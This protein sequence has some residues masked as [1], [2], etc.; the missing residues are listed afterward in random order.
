METTSFSLGLMSFRNGNLWFEEVV[1]LIPRRLQWWLDVSM[2]PDK[3]VK[4]W[5]LGMN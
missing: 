5:N 2:G 3:S 4:D 1:S